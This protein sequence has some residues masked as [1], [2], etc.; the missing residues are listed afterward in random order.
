MQQQQ[1]RTKL[2][3]VIYK[4]LVTK[5]GITKD[6]AIQTYENTIELALQLAA[7]KLDV[8]VDDIVM[9]NRGYTPDILRTFWDNPSLLLV[10]EKDT[11][12]NDNR[13]NLKKEEQV[14]SDLAALLKYEPL[15]TIS[16]GNTKVIKTID[17]TRVETDELRQRFFYVTTGIDTQGNP[18]RLKASKNARIRDKKA[19]YTDTNDMVYDDPD[20]VLWTNTDFVIPVSVKSK[21]DDESLASVFRF[22]SLQHAYAYVRNSIT[23][24]GMETVPYRGNRNLTCLEACDSWLCGTGVKMGRRDANPEVLAK[25]LAEVMK[26][27]SES[28]GRKL[29]YPK[30]AK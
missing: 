22:P 23:D 28:D 6:Y 7:K 13:F 1:Q 27:K 30:L 18:I 19:F 5:N 10:R 3:S 4:V 29:K 25:H 15:K 24:L 26:T 9:A 21:T 2:K 20:T 8:T 14:H 17:K 12:V 11:L 16:E